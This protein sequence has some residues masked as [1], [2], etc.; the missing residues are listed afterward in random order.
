M[1]NFDIRDKPLKNLAT[2]HETFQEGPH[3]LCTTKSG[4]FSLHLFQLSISFLNFQ[5]RSVQAVPFGE[6]TFI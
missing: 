1:K 4:C 5:W 3:E 2:D 6:F